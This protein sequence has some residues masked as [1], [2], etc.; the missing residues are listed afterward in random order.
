MGNFGHICGFTIH[1]FSVQVLFPSFRAGESWISDIIPRRKCV[2]A[3]Q[4]YR[5]SWRI[6]GKVGWEA[7]KQPHGNVAIRRGDRLWSK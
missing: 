3:W 4:N 1:F 7:A 5:V 6:Y 2:D